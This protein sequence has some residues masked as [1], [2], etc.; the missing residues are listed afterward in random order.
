MY[1]YIYE[2]FRNN[3]LSSRNYFKSKLTLDELKNNILSNSD[4]EQIEATYD[5]YFMYNYKG[6]NKWYYS[7]ELVKDSMDIEFISGSLNSFISHKLV[8]NHDDKY[9]IDFKYE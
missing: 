1:N 2:S 8:N 3:S 6:D 4:Y 9:C 7:I 5:Y